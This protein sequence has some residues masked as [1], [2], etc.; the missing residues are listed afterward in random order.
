MIIPSA[1]KI[2]K[3][4]YEAFAIDYLEGTL[5]ADD[6]K[7]FD[8]FVREHP[9][10]KAELDDYLAGPIIEDLGSEGF[11]RKA[12]LKRKGGM[13]KGVVLLVLLLIGI[14]V[15]GLRIGS[16]IENNSLP[17]KN[18]PVDKFKTETLKQELNNNSTQNADQIF[19]AVDSTPDKESE[20]T[21][22][23][24][25]S[26]DKKEQKSSIE[27]D[28]RGI[29]YHA[30][31]NTR[32]SKSQPPALK[33]D[34]EA[35]QQATR[36]VSEPDHNDNKVVTNVRPYANTTMST[37]ATLAKPP[38]ETIKLLE[39]IETLASINEGHLIVASES[40][41]G[42]ITENISPR[43]ES[44]IA[45]EAAET[46]TKKKS[47]WLKILVPQSFKDV[48]LE[49]TIAISNLRSAVNEIEEAIVPEILITK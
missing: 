38:T 26:L 27:K 11:E 12:D 41:Q 13:N 24:T 40:K 8:A 31:N 6:R 4:N 18:S 7:A 22:E 34:A 29:A 44:E 35:S 47:R 30:E 16:N 36:F 45:Y 3:L 23:L 46:I 1:M 28:D 5:S 9:E 15:I 21:A 43:L 19:L 42:P 14:F 17:T 25:R 33:T 39:S 32:S 48:E 10:V 2:N 20:S 37:P 49:N